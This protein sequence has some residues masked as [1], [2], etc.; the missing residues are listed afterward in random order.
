MAKEKNLTSITTVAAA[1]FARIVTSAGASVKAT[2]ANLAK[3][4]VETYNGSTV[5]GSAQSVKSALDSLN[6]NNGGTR[7]I[8]KELPANSSVTF[9]FSK[10]P[11]HAAF[12]TVGASGMRNVHIVRG[13]SNSTAGISSLT[14][15]ANITVTS[16]TGN[17]TF[18]SASSYAGVVVCFDFDEA[19]A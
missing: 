14:T 7:I 8:Q 3:Y 9:T 10:N 18:T 11:S 6:S 1:D 12:V 4:I 17:I 5:A 19:V 13:A 2:A 15:S 16:A